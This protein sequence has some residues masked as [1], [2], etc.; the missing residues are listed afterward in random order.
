[1]EQSVRDWRWRSFLTVYWPLLWHVL[2]LCTMYVMR[3][4]IVLTRAV[5]CW[6]WDTYTVKVCQKASVPNYRRIFS[7]QRKIISLYKMSCFIFGCFFVWQYVDMFMFLYIVNA[8]GSRNIFTWGVFNFHDLT[9]RYDRGVR[10][11]RS[12]VTLGAS[13][14]LY[15]LDSPAE[16]RWNF[17]YFSSYEQKFI[18]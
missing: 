4:P 14:S 1:M 8:V 11:M 13:S 6:F 7:D 18:V 16:F 15:W 9:A 2:W 10:F 5:C 12:R 3:T 17:A